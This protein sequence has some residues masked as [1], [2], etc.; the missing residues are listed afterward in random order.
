MGKLLSETLNTK[1]RLTNCASDRPDAQLRVDW[2]SLDDTLEI[3]RGQF[4][5]G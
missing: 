5:T 2:S 3:I 4:K 1:K